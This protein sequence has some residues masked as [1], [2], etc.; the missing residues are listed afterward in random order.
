MKIHYRP[1]KVKAAK[2]KKPLPE[3]NSTVTD[4][5]KLKLTSTEV[6]LII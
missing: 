4:L 6:V 5:D 2:N 1:P 3:W